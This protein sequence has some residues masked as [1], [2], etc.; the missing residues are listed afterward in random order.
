MPGKRC[1][2]LACE[3]YIGLVVKVCPYCGRLQ[4]KAT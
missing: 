2:N 4:T 1:I 3:K